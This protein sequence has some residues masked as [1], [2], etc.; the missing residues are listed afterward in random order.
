[1]ARTAAG[2]LE[3]T[4]EQ[5]QKT[6]EQDQQQISAIAAELGEHN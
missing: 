4:H 1:M 6:H 5:D 3:Q 2:Q